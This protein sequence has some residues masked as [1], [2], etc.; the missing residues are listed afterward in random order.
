MTI[1]L[2]A[3][4]PGQTLHTRKGEILTFKG[5]V[6]DRSRVTSY[7]HHVYS[8]TR[9]S[10]EEFTYTIEGK[11]NLFPS[12]LDIVAV[13]PPPGEAHRVQIS[14]TFNIHDFLSDEGTLAEFRS[15]VDSA[16]EAGYS[17]YT[18]SGEYITY[19][20]QRDETEEERVQRE[21][22]ESRRQLWKELNKEFGGTGEN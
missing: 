7:P 9:K 15:Q 14:E 4:V 8:A 5:I 13:G 12:Q 17:H 2:S 6:S 18:L 16:I 10:G 22:K 1:N 21:A 3:C 11:Y 19:L 20:G